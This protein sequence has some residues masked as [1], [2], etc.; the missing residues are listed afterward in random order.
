MHAQGGNLVERH[1][2]QMVRSVAKGGAM[3]HKQLDRI[4]L[5]LGLQFGKSIV[6]MGSD[7]LPRLH[8]R[9]GTLQGKPKV[10]IGF[11][12]GRQI[13]IAGIRLYD[14]FDLLQGQIAAGTETA[15]SQVVKLDDLGRL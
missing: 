8:E 11:P 4:L 1:D 12:V 10:A 2:T 15:F 3:S 14:P 9:L 13:M 7:S 5:N 6:D